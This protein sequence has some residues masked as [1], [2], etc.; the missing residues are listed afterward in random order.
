MFQIRQTGLFLMDISSLAGSMPHVLSSFQLDDSSVALIALLAGMMGGYRLSGWHEQLK[1][2][3]ARVAA[4]KPRSARK[5][6]SRN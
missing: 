3:R 4:S 5:A 1:A 6:D 2:R